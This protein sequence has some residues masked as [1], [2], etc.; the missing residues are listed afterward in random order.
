[1]SLKKKTRIFCRIYFIVNLLLRYLSTLPELEL[2]YAKSCHLTLGR[3][4]ALFWKY[5][6]Y[7]IETKT[8]VNFF[9]HYIFNRI[10]TSRGYLNKTTRDLAKHY[11]TQVPRQLTL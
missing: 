11:K 5:F 2:Q 6:K 1:M 3:S 10:Y 8:K 7:L 4:T 9:V